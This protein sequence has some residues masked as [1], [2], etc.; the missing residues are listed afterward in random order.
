MKIIFSPSPKS[1]KY[2]TDLEVK[3]LKLY[4]LKFTYNLLFN[5][6]LD[7]LRECRY[8]TYA[9]NKQGAKNLF[10]WLKKYNVLYLD[11]KTT[12]R[13]FDLSST[14]LSSFRPKNTLDE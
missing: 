1:G 14:M 8:P 12:K 2:K 4:I 7:K 9:I 3:K 5:S 6:L 13:S 11:A 10:S